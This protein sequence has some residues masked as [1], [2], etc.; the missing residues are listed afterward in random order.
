M[1]KQV[2]RIHPDAL[3]HLGRIAAKTG[4]GLHELVLEL[5]LAVGNEPA[6]TYQVSKLPDG[7][8]VV[9]QWSDN[10]KSVVGSTKSHDAHSSSL[11]QDRTDAQNYAT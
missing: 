6:A 11:L 9:D 1:F 2:A 4:F 5:V 3:D 10:K 7:S 8:L